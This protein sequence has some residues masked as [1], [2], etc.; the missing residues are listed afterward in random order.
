MAMEK[1][2]INGSSIAYK[3]YKWMINSIDESRYRFRSIFV[4]SIRIQSPSTRPSQRLR[5][6]LPRSR[7]VNVGKV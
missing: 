2:I 4:D 5:A 7:G 1:E 6:T 3:L